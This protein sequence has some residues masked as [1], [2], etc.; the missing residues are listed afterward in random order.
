MRKIKKCSISSTCACRVIRWRVACGAMRAECWVLYIVNCDVWC[1]CVCVLRV[2][3]CASCALRH[4]C[5]Y[6][7][8]CVLRVMR[9]MHVSCYA[10]CVSCV[11]RIVC[12]AC[13]SVYML[14]IMHCILWVLYV[15]SLC[16][17]VNVRACVYVFAIWI[18]YVRNECKPKRIVLT[19]NI[20]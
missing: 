15:A 5:Y 19:L 8:S 18:Q 1:G 13:L 4:A 16:I 11:L 2:A 17:R 10:C 14:R 7:S 20:N 9:V 3:C 12:H 6:H